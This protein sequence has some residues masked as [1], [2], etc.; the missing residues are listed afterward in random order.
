MYKTKKPKYADGKW[1]S[2]N[3]AAIGAGAGMLANFIPQDSGAGR[4]GG[5][6][7]QGISAGAALGPW[8]MAGGAVLGG[9]QALLGNAKM[10]R[11]EEI[12]L[13][14]NKIQN[15]QAETNISKVNLAGYNVNGQGTAYYA[16]GGKPYINGYEAEKGEIVEGNADLAESTKLASN[17][18]LVGGN[19]HE[20]GGTDGVGG[21]RIYSDRLKLDKEMAD[22]F[23]PYGLKGRP[24]Y[25]DA[26]KQVAK[27]KGKAEKKLDSKMAPSI[28]TGK[29]MVEDAQSALDLLFNL[30]EMS[31]PENRQPQQQ[32]FAMGGELDPVPNKKFGYGSI[33]H[34][35]TNQMTQQEWDY[36]Q[37]TM[38]LKPDK[39][40][41]KDL[42]PTNPTTAYHTS[43]MDS[44]DIVNK[45]L[46]N[47][48]AGKITTP[49]SGEDRNNAY[50]MS[51][52]RQP[53]AGVYN[54]KSNKFDY[55][56]YA[57]GGSLPKPK[58]FDMLAKAGNSFGGVPTEESGGGFNSVLSKIG[59]WTKKNEGQLINGASYLANLNA[60]KKLDTSV[61]R[62]YLN[63]P[64]YNYTDR[65]GI[66]KSENLNMYRTAVRGL[67]S[68][69]A[70][71][72]ASNAGALYAQTLNVNSQVNAQEGM[73]RDQYN[74]Q[75]GQRVDRINGY[76]T[77]ITND[78]NDKERELRNNKNVT[79]PLQARNAFL[80]GYAGNTAMTQKTNLD[81]QR[82][83]MSAYLNDENGVLNRID[84][85]KIKELKDSPLFTM[86]N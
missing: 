58:Y 68:S 44:W 26:A 14:Q 73:R 32:E 65:S 28:R 37:K 53:N 63:T 46:S 12:R 35:G 85:K 9:V 42:D 45:N 52:N 24:T 1:L 74:E 38:Q 43:I 25:A 84:Y 41:N 81:K 20:Q 30:Q 39:N 8:G 49:T 62:S 34:R 59:D 31:K 11:E 56:K 82:M 36:V 15:G 79:L 29:R 75:Y 77:G 50:T 40:I 33:A 13:Q 70:G 16:K 5:G 64:N 18:H 61:N 4:V 17:L 72:N 27:D 71:V 66:A 22:L 55:A 10:K 51:E 48:R 86:F 6:V 21:E 57:G 2:E 80:Q 54:P 69:S 19:K 7:M 67:S 78:A 60:I 23:K 47:F 83:L 76:N 3:S